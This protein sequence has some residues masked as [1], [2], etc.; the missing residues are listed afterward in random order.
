MNKIAYKI[1]KILLTGIFIMMMQSC[2]EENP[3]KTPTLEN[4]RV[5]KKALDLTQL[6]A[7]LESDADFNL[8]LK[9]KAE[10]NK[11]FDAKM[12]KLTDSESRRLTEII[13]AHGSFRELQENGNSDDVSFVNNIFAVKQTLPVGE[14]LKNVIFKLSEFEYDRESLNSIMIKKLSYARLNSSNGR[15]Q[16]ASNCLGACLTVRETYYIQELNYYYYVLNYAIEQADISATTSANHA[17][18]GC[19]MYCEQFEP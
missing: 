11:A 8:F 14:Y 6:A 10:G 5:T 12:D 13:K 9:A 18:V 16:D 2:D 7:L 4:P 1:T 17:F 15:T 3:L 19:R